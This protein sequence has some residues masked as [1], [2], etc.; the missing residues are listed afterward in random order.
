MPG[1]LIVRR[2]QLGVA[3]EGAVL[4]F[5]DEILGMLRPDPH[6]KGLG[7]HG[8]AAAEKI[9]VGVPGPLADGQHQ[10]AA[11]DPLRDAVFDQ[12]HRPKLSRL[13]MDPVQLRGEADLAPQGD[14]L[15]A[16]VLDHGPEPVRAHV[17][18][19]QDPDLL[20]RPAGE[21]GIQHRGAA[22]V[23][24]PGGQLPVGKGARA[25]LAEEGVALGIRPTGA[26]VPVHVLDP[27]VHGLA[28]I[29]DQGPIPLPGQEPAGEQAAGPHAHHHDPAGKGL[30]AVDQRRIAGRFPGLSVALFI[31]QHPPGRPRG[32]AHQTVDAEEHIP[33]LPG[34]HRLAQDAHF[35]DLPGVCPQLSGKGGAKAVVGIVQGPAQGR[36]HHA[37]HMGI[38]KKARPP[39]GNRA[40]FL[41]TGFAPPS[42]VQVWVQT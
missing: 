21:E 19:G 12:G 16:Q 18:L 15:V 29:D 37:H 39:W 33:F 20:L 35:P 40:S 24:G 28:P 10:G 34:V 5:V 4:A 3:G 30:L 8:K 9:P 11:V 26:P 17:G 36:Y 1:Q 41:I 25:A 31:R 13:S 42:S 14:D 27:L 23:L 22:R 38:L 32:Q 2:P 6:G 7:G